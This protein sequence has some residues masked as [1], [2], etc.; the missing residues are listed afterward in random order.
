MLMAPRTPN[1][2]LTLPRQADGQAAPPNPPSGKDGWEVVH[3]AR[4][5]SPPGY[6]S[7]PTVVVEP[8]HSVTGPP[9]P[10]PYGPAPYH[11]H[12][13]H[14]PHAQNAPFGA[15]LPVMDAAV[16]EP[17]PNTERM[18]RSMPSTTQ[19]MQAPSVPPPAGLVLRQW[20]PEQPP[21]MGGPPAVLDKRLVLLAE[22][23]STTADAYRVLRDQLLGKNL[24]RVVAVSSPQQ[25]DGKT[26]CAIN[27]ALALAEQPSTRVL[28]IDGNFFDPELA[29]IFQM[30]RL[31]MLSPPEAEA[32]LPPYRLAQVTPSLHLVGLL[33]SEM[34]RRRFEQH[35]FEAM[36][37][38]LCRANYDYIVV[39]TP[40]L[41][42]APA[43]LQLIAVT[44]ATLLAIRAGG[45]TTARELRRAAEQI[46]K[47]KALGIALIDA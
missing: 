36:I 32:W 38:R 12:H 37:D 10:S 5:A 41:H 1:V 14:A 27:L 24:P 40:A 33:K 6:P 35:R 28:L 46:P 42:G 23:D 22:P 29:H 18:A 15:R 2:P 4:E 9:P 39:D 31:S 8:R 11:P 3:P 47:E 21:T 7:S 30:E 17:A 13:P 26:T 25:R 20:E 19:A 43:V 44:D 34:P 45:G 16:E